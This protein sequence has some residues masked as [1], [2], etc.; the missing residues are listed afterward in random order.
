M[1][2]AAYDGETRVDEVV[3]KVIKRGRSYTIDFQIGV[4]ILYEEIS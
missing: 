2:E 4:I 3:G 1:K